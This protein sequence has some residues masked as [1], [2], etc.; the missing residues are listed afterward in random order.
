MAKQV[1]CLASL[2]DARPTPALPLEGG[3]RRM[4]L[5]RFPPPLAAYGRLWRLR[6]RVR[7]EG[8]TKI[9]LEA[10]DHMAIGWPEACS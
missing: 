8:K 4:R 10:F 2:R 6:G 9:L 7:E 1:R 5:D 3:G